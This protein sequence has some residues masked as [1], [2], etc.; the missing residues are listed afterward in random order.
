MALRY[1]SVTIFRESK[2]LRIAQ[3]SYTSYTY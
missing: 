3:N 1:G 2:T